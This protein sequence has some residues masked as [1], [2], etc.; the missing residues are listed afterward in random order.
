VAGIFKAEG[1]GTYR[2]EH[3]R[4]GWYYLKTKFHGVGLGIF[5]YAMAQDFPKDKTGLVPTLA[6]N[7]FAQIG[8]EVG[9]MGL[10]SFFIFLWLLVRKRLNSIIKNSL[11]KH[12]IFS[13]SLFVA[14]VNYLVLSM[15][16]PWFLHPK[17]AYMFWILAAY[18]S[19]RS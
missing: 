2:L 5:P 19:K 7:M 18:N 15:F 11:L 1:G 13:F 8:A 17:M 6:H 10:I 14:L 9:L 4:V 16:F 3:I 12:N